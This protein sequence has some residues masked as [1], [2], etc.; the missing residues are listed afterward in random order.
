MDWFEFTKEN[1][2][3]SVSHPFSM[4]PPVVQRRW[5]P[6]NRNRLL[7][8]LDLRP[9]LLLDRHVLRLLTTSFDDLHVL[10]ELRDSTSATLITLF[11]SCTILLRRLD[12]A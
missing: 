10:S 4:R 11:D 3:C 2:K 1:L 8:E 6:V 12:M 5:F 9:V 7:Q